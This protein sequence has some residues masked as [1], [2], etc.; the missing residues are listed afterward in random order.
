MLKI[1]FNLIWSFPHV[2]DEILHFVWAR[3]RERVCV[4]VSVTSRSIATMINA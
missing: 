2:N 1:M 4:F 3:E